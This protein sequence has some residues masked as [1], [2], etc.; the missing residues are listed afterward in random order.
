MSTE[1][2]GLTRNVLKLPEVVESDCSLFVIVIVYH[3]QNLGTLT[4]MCHVCHAEFL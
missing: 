1:R 2:M 3:P 4:P